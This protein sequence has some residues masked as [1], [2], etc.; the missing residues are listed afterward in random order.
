MYLSFFVSRA[1]LRLKKVT[2]ASESVFGLNAPF[3][4]GNNK[5]SNTM[6]YAV[7][8][9]EKLLF[10]LKPILLLPLPVLVLIHGFLPLSLHAVGSE[11]MTTI[12]SPRIFF[13]VY[14]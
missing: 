8:V 13:V 9:I 1:R 6:I 14:F 3:V 12:T 2:D 5:T 11:D 10:V 7:V 4:E